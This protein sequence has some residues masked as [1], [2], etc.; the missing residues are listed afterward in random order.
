MR[1]IGRLKRIDNGQ[2]PVFQITASHLIQ[3]LPE[4]DRVEIIVMAAQFVGYLSKT[5]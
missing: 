3:F 1:H 5:T 4:N 2:T